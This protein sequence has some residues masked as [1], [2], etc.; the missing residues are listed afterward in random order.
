MSG[1][2]IL[3]LNHEFP[4]VGGGASPVT[5]DLCRALVRKNNR[6][7]VVTMHFKGTPRFECID[8]VNVYRTPAMRRRADISH[9]AELAT[10]FPGALGKTL[11]L[12]AENRYDIIHCHFMVPGAPLG[13]VVSKLCRVPLIVTCHG[14]D[15][16]AHNPDRFGLVHKIIGPAWRFLARRIPLI[17]SP[18][19]YLKRSILQACAQA[20][21]VVVP[22]GIAIDQFPPLPK[23]KHILMCSRLFAFKGF[24]HVIEAVRDLDCDWTLNIIG[25]GP[26]LSELKAAARG[27]RMPIYFHGWLEKASA[28]FRRLHAQSSLFVFPSLAENFPTVL[29][30][31][32]SARMAIISSSAGGC[33]EVVG[34]AGLLVQPGDVAGFRDAIVRLIDS[35]SE[36]A[37]LAQ[38]AFDRAAQFS[39]DH[40]SQ[41]FLETYHRL[42]SVRA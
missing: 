28:E 14:T 36:R 19:E 17:T 24:Q 41:T 22:N 38:A 5:L 18:S 9:T 4:P 27:A 10:Y 31:A 1:L 21:V 37:R 20:N 42:L 6:V 26:Y 34:E 29:L 13:Y 35:P 40:V 32:M 33:P 30:D 25:E 15:V 2:K 7:D 3:M 23:T 39:W 8:G 12:I 16:P 11:S